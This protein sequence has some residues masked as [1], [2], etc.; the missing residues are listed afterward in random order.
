MDLFEAIHSRRSVRSYK[1]DPVTAEHLNEILD[2]ARWAPS[3]AN[4]Q[5]AEYIVIS[6]PEVKAALAEAVGERNPGRPAL[7]E[8]PL[9]IAGIGRRN[10]SGFKKGGAVTELGD[11]YMFDVALGMANLTLAAQALGYGTVHIG[12]ID[13]AKA[14][15][16]L[17]VP[18]EY[19]VVELVPL[20]VPAQMPN[21]TPRKPLGDIIH[22]DKF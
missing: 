2:A 6:D 10:L 7:F 21:T 14:A 9:V 16:V 3:W 12:M 11:W 4:T 5:C 15:Q 20:G 13:H 1:S 8:A 18:D 19:Q 17:G 22:N